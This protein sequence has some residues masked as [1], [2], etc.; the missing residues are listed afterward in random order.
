LIFLKNN[1]MT[2]KYFAIVSLFLFTIK[3][4]SQI[5][6]GVNTAGVSYD[7]NYNGPPLA[8][9]A[10]KFVGN[11]KGPIENNFSNL[12]NQLTPEYEGKWGRVGTTPES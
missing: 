4:Y 11:L 3:A 7:S 6:E 10:K 8:N 1:E 5:D 2:L 12:W 9:G